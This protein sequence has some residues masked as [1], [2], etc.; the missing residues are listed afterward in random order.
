MKWT[1]FA[2]AAAVACITGNAIAAWP[3]IFDDH[4]AIRAASAT[5]ASSGAYV[6]YQSNCSCCKDVWAGYCSEP[7]H[8]YCGAR[9]SHHASHGCGCGHGG[10]I[11]GGLFGIFGGHHGCNQGCGCG[12]PIEGESM[13]IIDDGQLPLPMPAPP[14]PSPASMQR[15]ASRSAGVTQSKQV[16]P[17]GYLR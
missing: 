14:T 12:E 15:S 4:N 16:I 5:V 17:A 9:H 2:A 6:D 7:G 10:G 13:I 8:G 1:A 11:L 3:S